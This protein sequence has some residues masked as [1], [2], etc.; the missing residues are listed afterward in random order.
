VNILIWGFEESVT[1]QIKLKLTKQYNVAFI[2]SFDNKHNANDGI[3][4]YA[5]KKVPIDSWDLE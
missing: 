2:G 3:F 5:C 1:V 4:E